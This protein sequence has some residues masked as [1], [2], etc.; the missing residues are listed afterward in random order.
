MNI[1]KASAAALGATTLL[2]TPIAAQNANVNAN[3]LVNV[4]ISNVANDLAEDLDVNVSN[5]PVTVQAPIGVAANVCNVAA[6][7]LASDNR[8]DGAEC[9]ATTMSQALTQTV[10]RQ[11]G[12][13]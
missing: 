5:I 10:Q 7:V 2:A 12:S 8:G 4:N 6:N 11:M 3:N 1:L 13:Q 9:D